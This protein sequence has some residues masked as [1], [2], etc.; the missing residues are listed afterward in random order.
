MRTLKLGT[1]IGTIG[2]HAPPCAATRR[3]VS[4]CRNTGQA[5]KHGMVGSC[6]FEPQTST[7]STYHD[8][9]IRLINVALCKFTSSFKELEPIPQFKATAK[10]G[11]FLEAR[12]SQS[13]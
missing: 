13:F 4:R 8:Y 2:P 5:I 3:I 11:Q 10:L 7:V 9:K 1:V 12:F 6:G